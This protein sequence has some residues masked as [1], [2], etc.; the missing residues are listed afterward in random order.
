[1][2]EIV[3]SNQFKRDLKLAKNEDYGL[4][5]CKRLLIHC[6]CKSRCRITTEITHCQEIMLDSENAT[7]NQIGCLSIE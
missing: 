6:R 3:P 4:N 1:M 5:Y 2:L 7:F